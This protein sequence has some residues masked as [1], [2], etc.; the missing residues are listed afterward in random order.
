MAAG[1]NQPDGSQWLAVHQ[2]A[3]VTAEAHVPEPGCK[4]PM[5]KNVAINQEERDLGAVEKAV[6]VG[7]KRNDHSL[8]RFTV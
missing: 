5:P 7:G 6:M 3:I 8:Q 1:T 2:S 4:Y